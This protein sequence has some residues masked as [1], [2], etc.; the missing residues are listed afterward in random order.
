MRT[1]RGGRAKVAQQ[2][3]LYMGMGVSGGEGGRP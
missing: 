2:G 3:L 1:Q